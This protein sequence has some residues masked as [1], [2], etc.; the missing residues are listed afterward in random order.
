MRTLY[1]RSA[2]ETTVAAG[3]GASFSAGSPLDNPSPVQLFPNGVTVERLR[4]DKRTAIKKALLSSIF[5]IPSA[6]SAGGRYRSLHAEK[7]VLIP[8]G[9]ARMRPGG[10][11]MSPQIMPLQI[12]KVG[13][14]AII[15]VPA[16]VTTMSGRRF[17]RAVLAELAKV[18]VK[19][20]VISGVSNS[21]AS[22]LATR[23]EYAKQWFEGAS[24][25]FGP[26]QQA[27]FQQEYVE[28][29]RA[30][31]RG[32]DVPPGPRPEDVTGQTVDLTHRVWF[33]DIP[34][35]KR[36][37]EVA[38][39]PRDAY[40]PGEEVRVSFWGGHPSN[41]YRIQDSF[42]V[43]E[44]LENGAFV[45]VAR[46][47]DPEATYRWQR[48]GLACSKITITW[49]TKDAPPGTYRIR[50]KGNFKRF[51]RVE[52]Y[53]GVTDTFRL[54]PAVTTPSEETPQEKTSTLSGAVGWQ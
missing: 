51:G 25:Q 32:E 13:T 14:L 49:I 26:H 28:L 8:N 16:E 36:F 46:D 18:G 19:Y 41:D 47:W 24:T 50:H 40:A 53:E 48:E 20:A 52:A 21:Y 3:M 30:I 43:V 23:E 27:G 7:P 54:A 37:G 42:L 11:T 2:G 6:G 4:R 29:C 31:V 44:R 9:I 38:E 12:L 1:V 39:P 10:P 34:I 33:D 35:G 5:F 17:K 22:Y 15:A 45:P